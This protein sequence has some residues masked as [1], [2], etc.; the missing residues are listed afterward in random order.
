MKKLLCKDVWNNKSES[1]TLE[2]YQALK[3]KQIVRLI[4]CL[5][6]ILSTEQ[7]DPNSSHK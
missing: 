4:Q 7:L 6:V 5:V 3:Q 1:I 2:T